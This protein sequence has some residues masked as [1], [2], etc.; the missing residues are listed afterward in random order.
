MEDLKGNFARLIKL[1]RTLRGE[2]GCAWDRKQDHKSLKPYLIEEVYEV[3]ESIDE[4]D[5]IRLKEELG[6]LFFQI[7]F[8]CQVAEENNEFTINDILIHLY[9]KMIHRH[10]HVFGNKKVDDVT[11]LIKQWHDIKMKEKTGQSIF[12]NVPSSL[13]ALFWAHKVQEKAAGVGFD[14]EKIQDVVIKIKEEIIELE[15]EMNE[16][17]L[18][19]GSS[20]LDKEKER[21]EEELGDVLFSLVNIARHLHINT[22]LALRKTIEKFIRRF[23]YIEEKISE[24]GKTLQECSLEEMDKLWEESKKKTMNNEK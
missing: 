15:E 1:M 4:N 22:E 2:T 7:V 9:D 21:I 17:I 14:W 8:H 13:P 11:A 16:G 24:S 5:A 18:D 20:I 3:I 6:D 12:R 19:S 10:P 23:R